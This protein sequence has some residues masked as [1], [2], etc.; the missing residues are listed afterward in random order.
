MVLFFY[1]NNFYIK[2]DVFLYKESKLEL[3]T[4]SLDEF[5]AS[6]K[7]IISPPLKTLKQVEDD[8]LVLVT[9]KELSYWFAKILGWEFKGEIPANVKKGVII[10]AP[11]TSMLDFFFGMA[12]YRY[13]KGIKGSYLAKKELFTGPFKFI[14]NKTGGIPVDRSKSN[15]LVDQVVNYFNEKD[16]IFLALAPEG[17]R[18]YTTKWKS[19]FYRIAVK[20]EV[21][22]ILGYLD[23]EKKEAGVGDIIYP[24]GDYEAD[25][26]KMSEFYKNISPFWI[27]KWNWNIV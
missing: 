19:G 14:F 17:T 8:P 13:L 27:K 12:T 3:S 4:I 7:G 25:A 11:H 26:K 15:N 18:S 21:P 20:A 1:P 6:L 22:I 23:F 5:Y 2:T 24:S 16:S 10:L 9:V